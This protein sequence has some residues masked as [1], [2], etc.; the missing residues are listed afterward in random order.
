[1]IQD[2]RDRNRTM[3]WAKP[4]SEKMSH[5]PC[6][7]PWPHGVGG[8]VGLSSQRAQPM[9]MSEMGKGL[10]FLSPEAQDQRLLGLGGFR[11][12]WGY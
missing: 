9:Q 4:T 5:Q 2:A 11:Q 8:G 3:E 1:M 10:H 12:E 6:N 7:E